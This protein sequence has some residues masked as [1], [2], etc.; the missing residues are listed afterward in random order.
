M[1]TNETAR[2]SRPNEIRKHCLNRDGFSWKEADRYESMERRESALLEA[3]DERP[4][5]DDEALEL[6]QLQYEL[7]QMDRAVRGRSDGREVKHAA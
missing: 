3:Y 2:W 5:T 4:L 7:A 1:T 6:Q